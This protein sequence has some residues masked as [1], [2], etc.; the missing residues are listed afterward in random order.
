MSVSQRKPSIDELWD[1]W[2]PFRHLVSPV[3]EA[4]SQNVASLSGSFVSDGSSSPFR[5]VLYS[6][7]CVC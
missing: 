3:R 5:V 4:L 7:Q 1:S 2:P 6:A